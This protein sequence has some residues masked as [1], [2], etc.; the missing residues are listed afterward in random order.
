M[1]AGYLDELNTNQLNLI[2]KILTIKATNHEQPLFELPFTDNPTVI[3]YVDK[4]Y[5]RMVA[6]KR[7]DVLV[8]N[9][10]KKDKKAE[11]IYKRLISIALGI[12]MSGKLVPNGC[13]TKPWPNCKFPLFSSCGA[14]IRTI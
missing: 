11:S 4:F 5:N 14:G 2:Q 3:H 7:I 1:N 12:W 8:G 6:E 9:K 13:R 10:E